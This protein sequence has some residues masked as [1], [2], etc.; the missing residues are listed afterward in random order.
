MPQVVN[1]CYVENYAERTEVLDHLL[2]N[3]FLWHG[4]DC[5]TPTNIVERYY[6]YPYICAHTYNQMLC[7]SKS[8]DGYYYENV[9]EFLAACGIVVSTINKDYFKIGDLTMTKTIKVAE[10]KVI[11]IQIT[12]DVARHNGY[13]KYEVVS[14]AN[15]RVSFKMI[16]SP[17]TTEELGGISFMKITSDRGTKYIHSSCMPEC[18]EA[19]LYTHGL[20]SS[21]DG[22]IM[23]C[24]LYDFNLYQLAMLTWNISICKHNTK[25]IYKICGICGE[26]EII[27]L[28]IS[29]SEEFHLYTYVCC[30]EPDTLDIT[31]N[32][33]A[34]DTRTTNFTNCTYNV[35]SWWCLSSNLDSSVLKSVLSIVGN[36]YSV[37]QD[38]PKYMPKLRIQ[39]VCTCCQAPTGIWLSNPE[40]FDA[41]NYP[42]CDE[43]R[44]KLNECMYCGHI[45]I[46]LPKWGDKHVCAGCSTISDCYICGL[47]GD[48]SHKRVVIANTSGMRKNLCFDCHDNVIGQ[49]KGWAYAR[50]LPERSYSWKRS[51]SELQI[52]VC[53]KK[54]GEVVALPAVDNVTNIPVAALEWEFPFSQDTTGTTNR[55]RAIWLFDNTQKELGYN[56]LFIA[57]HDGSLPNF[58]TEFVSDTPKS[59]G[60][61][62]KLYFD[63]VLSKLARFIDARFV[64]G[65]SST[66]GGHIHISRAS[67]TPVQVSKMLKFLYSNQEFMS[68]IC[69][70]PVDTSGGA[71]YYSAK[72]DVHPLA[73]AY[74]KNTTSPEKYTMARVTHNPCNLGNGKYIDMGTIEVR[75][76]KAPVSDVEVIQN[77]EFMFALRSFVC[78]VSGVEVDKSEAFIRYTLEHRK[79]FPLL[80]EKMLARNKAVFAINKPSV[81]SILSIPT[82]VST[83]ARW[84]SFVS[85]AGSTDRIQCASCGS[86]HTPSPSSIFDRSGNFM[87][88][89][90]GTRCTQCNTA[91]LRQYIHHVQGSNHLCENCYENHT[92]SCDDCDATHMRQDEYYL[93][94]YNGH[95]TWICPTC[96]SNYTRCSVTDTY[97]HYSDPCSHAILGGSN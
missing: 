87:C 17:R 28:P 54:A 5:W 45:G 23:E 20:A 11:K 65:H 56:D 1:S 63:G 26:Y 80:A 86:Y 97:Y 92:F 72:S 29:R 50:L 49:S 43:C 8:S 21:E 85:T 77:V 76:F 79:E 37:I 68:F 3:G 93:E 94:L 95:E 53:D 59:L 39:Q 44:A 70:R 46:N 4:E 9:P 91:E 18:T 90:C 6:D 19:A 58:A 27:T 71:H 10:G 73:F 82:R 78:N 31:F 64:K 41:T 89:N 75:A 81:G 34:V 25:K 15:G 61:W 66:V 14:V 2:S 69:G 13:F 47:E 12:E 42:L 36:I 24:S 55:D 96:Y 60:A 62:H 38:A 51:A 84:N 52:L 32:P 88:D 22:Y 67:F 35:P 83:R 40:C 16:N 30:P 7:G 57:K 74:N 48:M 33:S